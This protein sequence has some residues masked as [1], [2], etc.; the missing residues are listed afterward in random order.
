MSKELF[1]QLDRIER[2]TLLAAKNVLTL[3]DA[4]LMTGLSKGH[5]YKLTCKH[6]VPHYKPHGKMIYFDRTELECWMKQNRIATQQE[7]D[8]V[9]TNYVVTGR[10][11][12]GVK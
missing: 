10:M 12:G 4:A 11:E 1:Q 2:Y 9:A 5:F 7:V 6:L 8:T 3:E